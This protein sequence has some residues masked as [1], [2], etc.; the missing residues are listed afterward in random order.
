MAGLSNQNLIIIA[1]ATEESKYFLE[2][3]AKRTATIIL[4]TKIGLNSL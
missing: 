1:H 3:L 4:L 2:L